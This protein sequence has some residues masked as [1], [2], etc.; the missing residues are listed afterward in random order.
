M[1]S[2]NAYAQAFVS[3]SE[4]KGVENFLEFKEVVHIFESI[5]KMENALLFKR[6]RFEKIR[7][8][9]E[10]AFSPLV[11]HFLDIIIEDGHVDQL[12]EIEKLIMDTLIAEDLY[13]FCMV[14]SSEPLTASFKSELEGKIEKF[15]NT[16]FEIHYKINESIGS[17]IKVRVNDDW[18]DLSIQGRLNRLMAEVS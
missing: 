10:S 1:F 16:P 3:A 17:G 15:V 14:E 18:F 11:Y 4:E 8:I 2:L 7:E 9:F 5:P 12:G 6:D 13:S